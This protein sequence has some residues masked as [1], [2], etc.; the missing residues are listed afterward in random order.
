MADANTR[1]T[2]EEKDLVG[3]LLRLP[4]K[5]LESRIR[6]IQ[7]EIHEREKLRDVGLSRLFTSR[8]R[9]KSLQ[10]RAAYVG[11]ASETLHRQLEVLGSLGSVERD[12]SREETNS[13]QDLSRLKA[14]LQQAQEELA[15]E[16]EKL[17]LI[18][19]DEQDYSSIEQQNSN[20]HNDRHRRS[21]AKTR[22]HSEE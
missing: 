14:E 7:K 11:S 2:K 8:S 17:T 6:E 18:S 1:K 4:K 21:T 13:F 19:S 15:M 20:R 3:A 22:S 5:N 12:I 9:I 16:A 10:R